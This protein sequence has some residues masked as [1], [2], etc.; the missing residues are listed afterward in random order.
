VSY[1]ICC[2]EFFWRE[3]V[4][5]LTTSSTMATSP[6]LP[7]PPL[8]FSDDFRFGESRGEF[9]KIGGRNFFGRICRIRPLSASA[10]PARSGRFD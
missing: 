7:A 5:S 4:E 3:L 2:G 1:E 9:Q 6:R 10:L 8:E